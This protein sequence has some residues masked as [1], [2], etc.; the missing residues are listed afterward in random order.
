[1]QS[2]A[3]GFKTWNWNIAEEDSCELWITVVQWSG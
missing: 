1:M 2:R 3:R